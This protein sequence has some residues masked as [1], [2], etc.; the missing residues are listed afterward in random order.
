MAT[1]FGT[2]GSP[3]SLSSLMCAASRSSVCRRLQRAHL[4]SVGRENSLSPGK[5]TTGVAPSDRGALR[6]ED[7]RAPAAASVREI[8]PLA[9]SIVHPREPILY[10][11]AAGA[12]STADAPKVT[13]PSSRAGFRPALPCVAAGT[14]DGF[15]TTFALG[16][17]RPIKRR[18]RPLTCGDGLRRKPLSCY[19]L[20]SQPGPCFHR[21]GRF[22]VP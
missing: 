5:R 16:L 1:P 13:T 19:P 14:L 12:V 21:S 8:G 6:P 20:T 11:P 2:T 17:R 18:I 10:A 7:D 9:E 22:R 15:D 3:P 4:R